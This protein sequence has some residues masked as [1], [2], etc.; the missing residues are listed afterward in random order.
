MARGKAPTY[1]EQ[2][3]SILVT[4]A[5]LF[6]ENGFHNASMSQL[7][8][9]CGMS[10]ALLYHYYRDKEQILFDIVDTYMDR[11]WVLVQEA[12]ELDLP[13]KE[14]LAEAIK[15]FMDEYEHSQDQHMV[16]VQDLKFMRKDAF[17]HVVEK[18]RKVVAAFAEIVAD[19]EPSFR[20]KELSKPVTMVLFGMINWT[21]TWLR[22]KGSLTYADMADIVTDIFLHGITGAELKS[23][24]K[25]AAKAAPRLSVVKATAAKTI[26]AKTTRTP[27]T[28]AAVPAKTPA[29][30][31]AASKRKKKET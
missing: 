23:A 12:A 27:K 15:R 4:A 20:K 11:L 18:E 28:T 5:H 24:E 22:A 9:D 6:A 31:A 7:A 19:V 8:A 3:T 29:A 30:G 13:P 10:K 25:P 26:P 2:R 1:V 17:Q 14:K 16:V 21:F